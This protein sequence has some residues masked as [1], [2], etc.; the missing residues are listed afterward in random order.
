MV[1]YN[2]FC[3][4]FSFFHENSFLGPKKS[5]V[6]DM[7]TMVWQTGANRIVMVTKLCEGGKVRGLH[8]WHAECW[9]MPSD[10]VVILQQ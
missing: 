9:T 1:D 5:T 10:N 3:Y 4:I 6:I 2:I 7:W 8:L